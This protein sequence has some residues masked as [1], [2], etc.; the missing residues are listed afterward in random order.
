MARPGVRIEHLRITLP[1]GWRGEPMALADALRRELALG[2]TAAARRWA[3][4]SGR[5]RI[6]AQPDDSAESLARR[7][8]RDTREGGP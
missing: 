4:G 3:A 6:A 8:L 1:A 7:L 2:G 5:L